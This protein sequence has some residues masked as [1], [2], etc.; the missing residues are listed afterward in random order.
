LLNTLTLRKCGATLPIR[1]CGAK[2]KDKFND[3]QCTNLQI[4][5]C[6]RSSKYYMCKKNV[7]EIYKMILKPVRK[8]KRAQ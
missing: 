3:P 1:K 7:I 6:I 4:S 5:I 8:K 2:L